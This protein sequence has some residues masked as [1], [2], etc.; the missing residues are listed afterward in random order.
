MLTQEMSRIV[1]RLIFGVLLLFACTSAV[2]QNQAFTFHVEKSGDLEASDTLSPLS[3]R[4]LGETGTANYTLICHYLYMTPHVKN[5]ESC[6]PLWVGDYSVRKD[7][8]TLVF[9][10]ENGEVRYGIETETEKPKSVPQSVSGITPLN[11]FLF[12]LWILTL[13]WGV[14]WRTSKTKESQLPPT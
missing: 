8:H 9:T 11:I 7:G 14:I 2:A 3:Y 5:V 4:V 12:L 10:T 6:K 13:L 1:K